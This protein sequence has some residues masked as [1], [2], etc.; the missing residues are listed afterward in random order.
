[1][2]ISEK[3][4][5]ELNR[6]SR[7]EIWDAGKYKEKDTDIIEKQPDGRIRVRFKDICRE[8]VGG[9]PKN[10]VDDW[11]HCVERKMGAILL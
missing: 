10:L 8:E 7:G 3:T 1:M 4:I 6:I 9:I 2:P 5:L 11:Q